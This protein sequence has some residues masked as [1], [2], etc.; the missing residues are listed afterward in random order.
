[1][2]TTTSKYAQGNYYAFQGVSWFFTHERPTLG[3]EICNAPSRWFS[4]ANLRVRR[5]NYHMPGGEF[6][7]DDYNK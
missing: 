7:D 5:C 6:P 4:S 1:M 3:C 2:T